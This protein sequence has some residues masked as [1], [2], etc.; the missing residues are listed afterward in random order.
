MKALTLLS[1]AAS[2]LF[3]SVNTAHAQDLPIVESNKDRIIVRLPEKTLLLNLPQV[4]PLPI[5]VLP[6]FDP[7]LWD[8][9]ELFPLPMPLLSPRLMPATTVATTSTSFQLTRVNEKFTVKHTLNGRC[10]T[11]R[12]VVDQGLTTADSIEIECKG[13]C[14]KFAANKVPKDHQATIDAMLEAVVK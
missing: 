9:P 11:V 7:L 4:Q 5:P 12:G 10:I 3:I 13:V 1:G 2:I 8:I 6:T 14:E